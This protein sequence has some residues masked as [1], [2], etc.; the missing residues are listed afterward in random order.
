MV[1]LVIDIFFKYGFRNYKMINDFCFL[2]KIIVRVI[3]DIK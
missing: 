3:L 1:F 2:L